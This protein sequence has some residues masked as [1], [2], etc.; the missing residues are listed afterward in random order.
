[1][2][3]NELLAVSRHLASCILNSNWGNKFKIFAFSIDVIS[4]QGR[5]LLKVLVC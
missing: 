1:M 4:I 5:T 3:R 2:L